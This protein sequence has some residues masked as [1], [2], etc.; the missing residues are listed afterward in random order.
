VYRGREDELF[1]RLEARYGPTDGMFKKSWHPWET[2]QSKG[3]VSMEY[4][5]AVDRALSLPS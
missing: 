1:R 5:A 2:R 3:R 4:F